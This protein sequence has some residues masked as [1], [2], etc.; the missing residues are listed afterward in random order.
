MT[1]RF[2]GSHPD[3]ESRYRT[4]MDYIENHHLTV[5]GFSLE[6]TLIDNGLTQNSSKY[7]TCIS[8]PIE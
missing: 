6:I 4:L 2:P 3:A 5:V 8:I 1:I 7:V